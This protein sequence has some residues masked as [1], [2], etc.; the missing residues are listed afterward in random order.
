MEFI[1][2]NKKLIVPVAAGAVIAAVLN[3]ADLPAWMIG[4]AVAAVVTLWSEKLIEAY[5][6]K[7]APKINA[8]RGE[9]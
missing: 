8:R 5:D 6:T 9:Y 1:E 2:K 7:I 4:G 3:W